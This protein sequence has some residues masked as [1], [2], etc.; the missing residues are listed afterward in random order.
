MADA[1]A[2][3]RF[4]NTIC[5]VNMANDRN[6]VCPVELASSLDNKMRRWLQN[7]HDI[8]APFVKGGM[9]VLDI[10]CGPGF[11]SI[12]M[13]KMVGASGQ[14]I[15]ADLQQGML[16]EL[17]GKVKGTV[18]ESRIKTVQCEKDKI[19]VFDEVDFILA[20]YMVHE[21]PD[22]T[23]LFEQLRA[24]LKKE[25]QFLLVEPKLFHVSKRDF[26]STLEE[27]ESKGFKVTEGPKLLL[28]WSA[29]L[30]NNSAAA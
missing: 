22:K 11:F 19:N 4:S 16:Q 23:S 5:G 21:V 10:G 20:F 13:A 9:K 18:L 26:E 17:A 28:S 3:G 8:L 27:A 1:C 15:S 7:P 24:V 30:G 2:I 12:E 25:G 29:V 6:R 14:V